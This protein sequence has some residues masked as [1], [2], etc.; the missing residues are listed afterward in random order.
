MITMITM[1]TKLL[2]GFTSPVKIY[3]STH[4]CLH[5]PTH[6][7]THPQEQEKCVVLLFKSAIGHFGGKQARGQGGEGG[8]GKQARAR[9]T[10]PL[11]A[12]ARRVVAARAIELKSRRFVGDRLPIW[13]SV[14]AWMR[15]PAA[16]SL[17]P[18]LL[19]P[20]L[21]PKSNILGL[22]ASRVGSEHGDGAASGRVMVSS[23]SET[24]RLHASYM[25]ASSMNA[26]ALL[27]DLVT[28][29][30]VERCVPSKGTE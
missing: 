23:T 6:A 17:G 2:L 25:H 19:G 12:A 27:V 1:I 22:N 28:G 15:P 29:S 9:L 7:L 20:T 13:D 18:N 16:G 11:W 30:T 14:W 4:K 26:E 5:P 3:M 24:E 21:G 8:G 10:A